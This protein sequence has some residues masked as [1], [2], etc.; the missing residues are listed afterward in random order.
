M[1]KFAK[2]FVVSILGWQV[3]RL[4]KKHSFKIV[5]IAGSIGKTSTKF[6]VASVLRQQFRVQFQEGNYN[7]IVTVP[8][9]FFGLPEPPLT[10]PLAWLKT[11]FAIERQLRKPYPYD[12]VAVELSTDGPGQITEFKKYIRLD[13]AVLTAITPEHMEFFS[14]LAAVA[15]EET[16]IA[17][18]TKQLIINTDLCPDIYV[19][20]L[21]AITYATKQSA[22]YQ[23]KDLQFSQGGYD[24]SMQHQG[25]ELFRAHH[26]TIA[27]TQ[28]YSICAA[29]SVGHQLGMDSATLVKG[30]EDI[31]PVNGRMYHL[32]GIN[33]STILD[34]TYNASPEASVAAL[35][36]LYK[37]EAPQKIAILGNMNELGQF[38]ADA[39]TQIGEHCDPR[40]LDLVATIGP[41]ANQYLAAAAEKKG[42]QV[43]RFDSPY[44]AGEF[45]KNIVEKGAIVLAKGS[46]NGVFAE[47]T[48]KLLL[49]NPDDNSKL[50][51]QSTY[52][53]KI[54]QKQFGTPK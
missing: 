45:L 25:Q 10:N 2:H 29:V 3:R 7:D 35:D 11:F 34:D 26:A 47:E 52:W 13:M 14:D 33:D 39:H 32:K 36:T 6:A 38:S 17:A 20:K 30:I 48:V 23:L 44:K 15:T 18:Y 22:D 19:G 46:Q 5:G 42:C 54:K 28:L 12:V 37:L 24:F 16:A 31:H 21:R 27:E 50:V 4:R 43:Q 41:D 40:Q 49:K 8:L 53:Q 1:K 51:R 9:I